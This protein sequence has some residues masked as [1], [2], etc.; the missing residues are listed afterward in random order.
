MVCSLHGFS[1]YITIGLQEFFSVFF[2]YAHAASDVNKN[3]EIFHSFSLFFRRLI[4]LLLPEKE[5]ILHTSSG[6]GADN[7][8]R[9]H[10][11]EPFY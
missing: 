6:S 2:F 3:V 11:D 9:M 1:L 5:T 10:A 4:Q 7:L 8:F